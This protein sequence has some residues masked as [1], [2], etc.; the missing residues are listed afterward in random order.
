MFSWGFPESHDLLSFT[1]TPKKGMERMELP[2]IAAKQKRYQDVLRYAQ[3]EQMDPQTKP[4]LL[5]ALD[6]YKRILAEC[7]KDPAMLASC[8]AKLATVEREID[9]LFNTARLRSAAP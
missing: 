3:A 4:N 7:W 1:E 8:D 2:R 6:N 9:S 5:K